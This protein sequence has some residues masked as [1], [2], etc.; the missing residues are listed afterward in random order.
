MDAYVYR[1]KGL[2]GS[3]DE[4]PDDNRRATLDTLRG[5]GDPVM[6]S[7]TIVDHSE[8]D[9]DGF[10]ASN[11]ANESQSADNVRAEIKSLRLRSKARDL[12]ARELREGDEGQRK[13]MLELESRE[14]VKQAKLL[15][16]QL[17]EMAATAPTCE[18]QS[19]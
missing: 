15:S 3:G 8:L 4:G 14:L 2:S 11:S 17:D 9:S 19:K 18:R 13:Y 5:R 1:F 7:Q 12:E 6:E 10:F 16:S